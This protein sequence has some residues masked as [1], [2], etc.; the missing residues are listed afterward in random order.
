MLNFGGLEWARDKWGWLGRAYLKW[1]ESI[2]VRF[3][4]TVIADNQHFVDYVSTEYGIRSR[5]IE[6][7]GD[8]CTVVDHVGSDLVNIYPFLRERYYLSVSRAQEDNNIHLLLE[9]FDRMPQHKIVIVSNWNVSEYGRTLKAK[10]SG[11]DNLVLLDAIYDLRVLNAIRSGC[12]VYI[13][14]HSFCG[15]APSL[16]EIM[17]LGKPVYSFHAYTNLE[18]TERKA[19]FFSTPDDLEKLIVC[20]GEQVVAELGNNMKEIASRRYTWDVIAKK[21]YDALG[22]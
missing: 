7:G 2:G 10:Y 12:Y 6:Y 16:V 11:I 19:L 14:S 13:H 22:A 9:A 4:D 18:T 3:S 5:L 1:A 20:T 8:H 15:T 17:S 21:Y